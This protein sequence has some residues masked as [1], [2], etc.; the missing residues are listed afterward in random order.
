[1]A[2]GGIISNRYGCTAVPQ[3]AKM[4]VRHSR[5]HTVAWRSIAAGNST[6]LVS[7]HETS[8]RELGVV[9]RISDCRRASWWDRS[10]L[11]LALLSAQRVDLEELGPAVRQR[12]QHGLA[13]D[14]AQAGG[15]REITLI[16][17][18]VEVLPV[19]LVRVAQDISRCKTTAEC[20]PGY[21]HASEDE[22]HV[23]MLGWLDDHWQ[24]I[25]GHVDLPRPELDER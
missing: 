24:Q 21:S 15:Q 7:V 12:K 18:I 20:C 13:D 2:G 14:L 23:W 4:A 8:R 17:K 19:V 5:P 10:E 3:P 11:L 22:A 25:A 6:G 1:M 16:G 9:G